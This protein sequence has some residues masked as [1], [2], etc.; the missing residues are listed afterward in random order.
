MGYN[1]NTPKEVIYGPPALFGIGV[2]D[3][4]IEQCIHQL[5]ALFGHI[6]QNSDTSKMMLI[7][8]QWCQVQAGTSKKLLAEP[9]DDIDYIETCWIMCIRD[10][11]RTYGLRINLSTHEEPVAQLLQDEFLMDA[12]R[13]RGDC[14]ATQMQQ[15]NACRMYLRATRLSDIASADGKNLRKDCLQGHQAHSFCSQMRW[16]RQGNPPKCGGTYGARHCDAFS[17]LMVVILG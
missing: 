15:I 8:L 2:H 14:T 10:F 13:E 11:L 6:R 16:P 4:Y 12:I 1:C 9:K 7:E 17:T 3:L 5:L